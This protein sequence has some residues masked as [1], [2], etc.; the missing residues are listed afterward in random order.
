M[1][2]V[3]PH[4]YFFFSIVNMIQYQYSV[5]RINTTKQS[6]FLASF[7]IYLKHYLFILHSSVTDIPTMSASALESLN[8]TDQESIL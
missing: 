3:L 5:V 2:A 8:V 6:L 7:N 1:G 4:L